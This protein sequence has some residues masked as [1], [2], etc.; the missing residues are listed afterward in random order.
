MFGERARPVGVGVDH[1][2]RS[3]L[4]CGLRVDVVQVAAVGVC[5]DLQERAG[6]DRR[7]DDAV[8]VD[9]VRLAPLDQPAGGVPDGVD[10]RVAHR[11]H[12]AVGLLL[13]REPEGGVQARDHPVELLEH[14]VL[15]VERAVGQDVGLGARQDRHPVDLDRLDALHLAQ[16]L[17]R[18]DVI[19]EPVR[20][21]VVGYRDVLVAALERRQ[22]HL[23]DGGVT[24]GESG[25]HVKVAAD[26]LEL[27]Q[28]GEA[29]V[30][31]RREL[32]AVLA[33]LG[34]DPLHA[35][36]LVDLL[37]GRAGDRVAAL[38]VG[39]PVLAHMQ[40]A[41]DGGRPQRLVVPARAGEVLEQVP[42]C[43]LGHDAQV[44]GQPRMRQRL[45]PGL[46]R[47]VQDVD[48]VRGSQ[49]T[50]RTPSSRSW[51]RRCRGP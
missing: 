7:G 31:C 46:P 16:Q 38:L 37:L 13:L 43:L 11:G 49:S 18:L 9:R 26:V 51:R 39:D 25:V 47:G 28:L 36:L 34:R 5:V 42:E 30:A 41:L 15:V 32:A 24:V 40:A 22:G 6:L 29:A 8:D 50:R 35:E 27:D 1:E 10:E 21:R 44:D 17:V 23:L 2:H 19:S 14:F 33:Q 20:G 3:R 45:R 12:H 4:G 48:G